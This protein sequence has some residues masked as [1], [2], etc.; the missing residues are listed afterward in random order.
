MLIQKVLNSI[1]ENLKR[2]RENSREGKRAP[3]DSTDLF[4]MASH[5]GGQDSSA[6]DS[7]LTIIFLLKDSMI[8]FLFIAPIF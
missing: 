7:E 1:K 2:E 3:R 4:T 6:T 5:L 8:D